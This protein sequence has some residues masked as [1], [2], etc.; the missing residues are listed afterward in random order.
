MGGT[1][2]AKQNKDHTWAKSV[3]QGLGTGVPRY[4]DELN[5]L[6]QII[7]AGSNIV[8]LPRPSFVSLTMSVFGG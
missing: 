1:K 6:C 8:T 4:M 3:F 7:V 2:K 5:M